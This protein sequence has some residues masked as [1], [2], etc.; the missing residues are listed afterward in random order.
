[1][2]YGAFAKPHVRRMD[3][4]HSSLACTHGIGWVRRNLFNNHSPLCLPTC[5]ARS[6][7]TRT[8]Q[9]FVCIC[10]GFGC[11]C[12]KI[13]VLLTSCHMLVNPPAHPKCSLCYK[14]IISPKIP[15]SHRRED[16]L[17]E[18][19]ILLCSDVDRICSSVI[20]STQAHVFEPG[21]G[22]LVDSLVELIDRHSI[23]PILK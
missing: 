4:G 14:G 15:A 23:L 21:S 12:L 10:C 5:V 22:E 11:E 19:G 3:H 7:C 17:R 16:P 13:F 9:F 18:V 2:K 6:D 8:L 1:M 20:I